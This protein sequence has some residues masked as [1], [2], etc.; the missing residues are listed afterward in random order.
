MK[1][2]TTALVV[3]CLAATGSQGFTVPTT[4]NVVQKSSSTTQMEAAFGPQ[5]WGEK[6]TPPRHRKSEAMN[7]DASKFEGINRKYM[8]SDGKTVVLGNSFLLAFQCLLVAPVVCLLYP[9]ALEGTDAY[10][11]AGAAFHVAL[12]I[13]IAGQTHRVRVAFDKDAVEFYNL[14][15]SAVKWQR[16]PS[17]LQGL[18]HKPHNSL[19]SGT[20]NRWNYDTITSYYFYPSIEF[21]VVCV[22]WEDETRVGK[23]P[24]YGTQPHFFPLLFSAKSFK[25]EM[26]KHGVPYM[27]PTNNH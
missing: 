16:Y 13:W 20:T 9:G 17:N 25:E 26:D 15:G 27:I 19:V 21:P 18:E 8:A 22:L 12:G 11:L 1:I 3:L 24:Y 6:Q 5:W 7:V 4:K 10:G 14:Q 2:F 23:S